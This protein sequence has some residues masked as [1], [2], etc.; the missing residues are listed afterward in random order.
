MSICIYFFSCVGR[1]QS[2]RGMEGVSASL[3]AGALDSVGAV[4]S[5][6]GNALLVEFTQVGLRLRAIDASK[7]FECEAFV[8]G[9]PSERVALHASLPSLAA[10][11]QLVRAAGGAVDI[12]VLDAGH[13]LRF[14]MR[15]GGEVAEAELISVQF[16]GGAYPE[17]PPEPE[18]RAPLAA[19][20]LLRAIRS[21]WC[22]ASS[23]VRF[24]SDD[25]GVRMSASGGKGMTSGSYPLDTH[26]SEAWDVSVQLSHAKLALLRWCAG[27]SGTISMGVVNG[28]VLSLRVAGEG[29]RGRVRLAALAGEG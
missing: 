20:T 29:M 14:T 11:C 9:S 12:A 2:E 1:A 17:D 3:L 21:L 19:G 10:V 23:T 18:H 8:L 7:S 5:P 6:L 28:S 16:E 27:Q 13:G 15:G 4:A 24:V 26:L 22:D 25:N